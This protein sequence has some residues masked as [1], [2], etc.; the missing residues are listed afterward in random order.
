MKPT[1]TGW[2]PHR[3]DGRKRHLQVV[4]RGKKLFAVIPKTFV[5]LDE[6]GGEWVAEERSE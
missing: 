6:L 2:Y 5:P 3:Q 4:R 1:K